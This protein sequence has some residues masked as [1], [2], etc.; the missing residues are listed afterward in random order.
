MEFKE[1][2]SETLAKRA[3]SLSSLNGR[4]GGKSKREKTKLLW[5][6]LFA[7]GSSQLVYMNIST[8]VPDYVDENYKNMSSLAVGIMFA[9]Y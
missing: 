6:L 3:D 7:Q 5:A 1:Y 2:E 8:L 4:G 9:A